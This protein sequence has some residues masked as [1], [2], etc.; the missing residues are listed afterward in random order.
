[1]QEFHTNIC[2]SWDLREVTMSI[3]AA[4][5]ECVEIIT[6]ACTRV[7]GICTY[8]M[9]RC[10]ECQNLGLNQVTIDDPCLPMIFDLPLIVSHVIQKP[11]SWKW[12]VHTSCCG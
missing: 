12:G 10:E 7:P 6:S 4:Q 9:H 1:M 2:S 3:T 5:R 11:C 8:Q